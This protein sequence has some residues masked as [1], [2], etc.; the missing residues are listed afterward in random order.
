M[1]L[2]GVSSIYIRQGEYEKA[3]PMLE[4]EIQILEELPNMASSINSNALL[5]LAHYRLGDV[6]KA[7]NY[8]SI[9][10]DLASDLSPTVYSLDVGFSAVAEVYFDLWEKALQNPN[11]LLDANRF[12]QLT[13]KA[14]KLLKGFRNIFPIGQP[15][16]AFYT[17]RWYWNLGKPQKAVKT[18]QA[19]LEAAKKYGLLYEEGLLHA[20]LGSSLRHMPAEQLAHFECAAQVF[21]E[22]GAVRD[23]GIVKALA[24]EYRLKV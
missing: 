10:L 20:R 6:E 3:I 23:L 22:M 15:Y 12:K 5:A 14:L 18:W 8:A 1:A 24:E 11:G 17:G 7:L 21:G 9:V 16:L 13:E 4:E 2:F 19:G